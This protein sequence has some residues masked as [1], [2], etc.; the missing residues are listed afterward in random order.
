MRMKNRFI[1]LFPIQISYL[2][3]KL[4]TTNKEHDLD[5]IRK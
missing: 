4:E 2:G 5:T 1:I 3:K